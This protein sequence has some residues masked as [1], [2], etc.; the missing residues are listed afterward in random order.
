[1]PGP[2]VPLG[3]D[4]DFALRTSDQRAVG[5]KA[6]RVALDSVVETPVAD[7]ILEELGGGPPLLDAPPEDGGIPRRRSAAG[8]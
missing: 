6:F 2:N 8:R 5:T 4:V 7:E 1:M 3:V